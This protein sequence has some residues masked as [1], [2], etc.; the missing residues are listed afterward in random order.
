MSQVFLLL[1]VSS[2]MTAVSQLLLKKGSLG[3]GD[4]DISIAGFFNLIPKILQNIWLM[5]GLVI[6]GV[7][8]IFWV[9]ILS[10]IQINVVYPISVGLNIF[11]ITLISW[12]LFKERLSPIQILGIILMTFSI[13][14][15]LFKKA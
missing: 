11:L 2:V 1:I 7:S 14:L 15:I 5:T 4:L 8:F 12:F 3:L 13:F 10:K 6:F 9:M